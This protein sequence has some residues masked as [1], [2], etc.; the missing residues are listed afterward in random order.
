MTAPDKIGLYGGSFDPIHQGHLTTARAVMQHF[1]LNTLYLLPNAT[2]PHKQALR[3]PYATRVQMIKAALADAL[4]PRLQLS[5]LEQDSSVRHYT[6]ETLARFSAEHPHTTPFFIMGMDSLLTLD[7]W[8][9]PQR[10]I[11]YAHIVVLPR[12]HYELS[13]LKPEIAAYVLPFLADKELLHTI[14]ENTRTQAQK[15]W[16]QAQHSLDAK[17]AVESGHQYHLLSVQQCPPFDISSTQL[18]ALLAQ[19]EA[20]LSVQ[21]VQTLQH[22]LSPQVYA[23][24]K[25]KGLYR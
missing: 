18:R 13:S 16:K 17:A 4:D 15:L 21:Q 9:E 8:R 22:A 11:E 5:F 2:P 6:I 23:L 20:H 3:L 25:S 7:T 14:P 10:L 19:D 1:S 24:I 12:P